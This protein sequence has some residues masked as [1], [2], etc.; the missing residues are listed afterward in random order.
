MFPRGISLLRLQQNPDVSTERA[1]T[2]AVSK[3]VATI[4]TGLTYSVAVERPA[5]FSRALRATSALGAFV[6]AYLSRQ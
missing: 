6:G 3:S 2:N 5:E 4:G 1:K